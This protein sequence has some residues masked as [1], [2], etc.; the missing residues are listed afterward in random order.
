MGPPGCCEHFAERGQ[1]WDF[2]KDILPKA[3]GKTVLFEYHLLVNIFAKKD[4]LEMSKWMLAAGDVNKTQLHSLQLPLP[5]PKP[6]GAIHSFHSNMSKLWY[7][8]ISHIF[9]GGF[10]IKMSSKNLHLDSS[11]TMRGPPPSPK[12]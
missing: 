11:G 5:S 3:R 7:F 1:V 10:S 8:F 2:L 12:P 4:T 6:R 9:D